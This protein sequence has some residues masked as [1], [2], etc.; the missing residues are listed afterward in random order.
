MSSVRSMTSIWQPVVDASALRRVST[1]SRVAPHAQVG[2]PSG[3]AADGVTPATVQGPS[4]RDF[5]GLELVGT[6]RQW[7]RRQDGGRAPVKQRSDICLHCRKVRGVPLR[8]AKKIPAGWTIT[9][10]TKGV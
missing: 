3:S 7:Q 9:D 10:A 8:P 2:L 6:G 5:A 1:T 4:S